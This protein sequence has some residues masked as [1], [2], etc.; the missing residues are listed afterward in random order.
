LDILK[1]GYFIGVA[2]YMLVFGGFIQQI[3]D[4]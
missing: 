2:F 1:A 3:A 4:V